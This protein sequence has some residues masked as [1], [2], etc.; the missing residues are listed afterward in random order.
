MKQDDILGID[1]GISIVIFSVIVI[2]LTSLKCS[3]NVN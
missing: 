1:L 2:C 3:K